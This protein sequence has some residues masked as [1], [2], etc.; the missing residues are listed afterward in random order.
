MSTAGHAHAVTAVE[1][2]PFGSLWAQSGVEGI[3]EGGR[4]G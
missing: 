4:L 2:F 3:T 1:G